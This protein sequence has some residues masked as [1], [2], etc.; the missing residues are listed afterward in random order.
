MAVDH[1]HERVH[2][3]GHFLS[4]S[5]NRR[6]LRDLETML[7]SKARL[8]VKPLS[9]WIKAFSKIYQVPMTQEP[10]IVCALLF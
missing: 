9:N 6:P 5:F 8:H 3:F 2:A 10:S 4:I 7:Q 1:Y